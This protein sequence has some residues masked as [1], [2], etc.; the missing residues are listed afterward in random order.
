MS[1]NSTD[2]SAIARQL[3]SVQFPLSMYEENQSRLDELKASGRGIFRH[4]QLLSRDWVVKMYIGGHQKILG[5]CAG[6]PENLEK[7]LRFSD[8][9]TLFFWKYRRQQFR[10][11]GKSDFN[12]SLTQAEKDLLSS[13]SCS[14]L[15]K[16][17]EKYLK[18][19]LVI[20]AERDESVPLP[21]K[22]RPLKDTLERIEQALFT[23][24]H[25]LNRL[26]DIFSRLQKIEEK[27]NEKN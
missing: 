10:L 14:N 7:V 26:D 4:C 27:I 12:F 8:C 11:A 20:G 1:R 15:L 3:E 9:A 13:E 24:N 17:L 2:L 5:T 19:V 23:V 6:V 16:E 18:A 25:N 22:H 21:V